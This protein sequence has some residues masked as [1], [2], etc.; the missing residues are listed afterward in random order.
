MPAAEGARGEAGGACDKETTAAL[1]AAAP[2]EG[3]AAT[4]ALRFWVLV[5]EREREREREEV[6]VERGGGRKT[7]RCCFLSRLPRERERE[8]EPF[9]NA[10]ALLRFI[11]LLLS[12]LSVFCKW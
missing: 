2:R 9:R 8:R 11:L 6:E 1:A 3:P 10:S 7:S 12:S 4:G 5:L